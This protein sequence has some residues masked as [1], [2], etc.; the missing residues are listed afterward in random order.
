[1]ALIWPSVGVEISD[2]GCRFGQVNAVSENLLRFRKSRVSGA[3][4]AFVV[5]GLSLAIVMVVYAFGTP[6]L[7]AMGEYTGFA[8]QA[9]AGKLRS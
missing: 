2:V 6:L 9:A 7:A 5:V 3:A 4:L 1:M 8:A